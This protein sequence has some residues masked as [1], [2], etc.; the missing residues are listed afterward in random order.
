[1]YVDGK[2]TIQIKRLVKGKVVPDGPFWR[3][4]SI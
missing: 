4:K 1:M 3:E 2:R